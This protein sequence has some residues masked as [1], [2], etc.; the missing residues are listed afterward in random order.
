MQRDHARP[1]VHRV[2][3][4]PAGDGARYGVP[5]V[6]QWQGPVGWA[7]ELEVSYMA[8]DTR[9]YEPARGE[10]PRRR[11][12]DRRRDTGRRMVRD[13]RRRE[14]VTVQFERRCGGDRRSGVQRRAQSERRISDPEGFHRIES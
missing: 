14:T 4:T 3:R 1:R 7:G 10:R 8:N 5:D 2:C 13:R 11:G 6:S 12:W 9:L